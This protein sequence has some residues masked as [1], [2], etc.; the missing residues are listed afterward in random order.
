MP[1]NS[2]TGFVNAYGSLNLAAVRQASLVG[3]S[4]GAI[5]SALTQAA[6]G[7]PEALARFLGFLLAGSGDRRIHRVAV[8]FVVGAVRA[9]PDQAP[10]MTR[11][12]LLAAPA[13]QAAGLVG[14]MVQASSE[15]GSPASVIAE[16]AQVAVQ[17]LPG[18][19]E[20]IAAAVVAQQPGQ[21]SGLTA[22]M[23]RAAPD[24]AVSIVRAAILQAPD[25]AAGIAGAAVRANP[26]MASEIRS[27]ASD[28]VPAQA[29]AIVAATRGASEGENPNRGGPGGQPPTSD[30]GTTASVSL[31]DL[32]ADLIQSTALGNTVFDE[33]G[34]SSI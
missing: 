2:S 32:A 27:L 23:V 29:S 15:A 24:R 21:A 9:A 6:G 8:V 17:T 18:Q 3:E 22:A 4:P 30:Q 12:F 11:T 10:A 31:E 34:A 19:A 5:A 28:L 16:I 13:A 26:A 33:T 14:A 25:Q 20:N 7:S 1:P